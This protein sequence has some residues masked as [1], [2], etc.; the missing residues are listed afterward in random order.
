MWCRLPEM[1]EFFS[2]GLDNTVSGTTD[3]ASYETPFF[4]QKGQRPDLIKLNVVLE[5]AGTLW[6]KDIVLRKMPLPAGA[7]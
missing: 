4:L 2:K 1:G 5:G 3:W 7:K 6:I